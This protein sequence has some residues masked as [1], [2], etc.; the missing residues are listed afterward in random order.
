MRKMKES[1]HNALFAT[2]NKF[3]V[4]NFALNE[5]PAI[6]DM[7]GLTKEQWAIGGSVAGMLYGIDF[8]RC[9]HD[10]DI[11][12]PVGLMKII[13]DRVNHSVLFS[14]INC[15]SSTDAEWGTNHF[16]FRAIEG[17]II[18]IIEANDFYNEEAKYAPCKIY[19]HSMYNEVN[20]MSI[21]HLYFAKKRYNRAKD[22]DDVVKLKALYDEFLALAT[23]EPQQPVEG[24]A[25]SDIDTLARL[26]AQME[27]K[28]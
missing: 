19:Y 11:I 23:P 26:K 17:Q 27:G 22:Y 5:V 13:Q 2:A 8:G 25:L 1:C 4:I 3:E 16:A 24:V 12:V 18:D 10:V 21:N 7:L 28:A 14:T 9:P 15:T 20:V 6:M